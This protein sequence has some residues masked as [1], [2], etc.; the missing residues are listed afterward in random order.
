VLKTSSSHDGGKRVTHSHLSQSIRDER[1]KI[2]SVNERDEDAMTERTSR[3]DDDPVGD[4]FRQVLDA[5]LDDDDEIVWNP[6]CVDHILLNSP[7]G[8]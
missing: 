5:D 3:T 2:Y 6:R 1:F 4:A 7:V 8:Y